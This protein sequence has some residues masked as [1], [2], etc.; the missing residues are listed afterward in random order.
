MISKNTVAQKKN[1]FQEQRFSGY[2]YFYN[3]SLLNLLKMK[4]LLLLLP[5]GS[6]LSAG[7]EWSRHDLVSVRFLCEC[8]S[9]WVGYK[10]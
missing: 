8:G 6:L 2:T 9:G 5:R 7:G 10:K 1:D 3:D 4:P